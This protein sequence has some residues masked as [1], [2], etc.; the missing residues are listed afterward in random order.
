M[1]YKI[2]KIQINMRS[3]A[4]ILHLMCKDNIFAKCRKVTLFNDALFQILL[5]IYLQTNGVENDGGTVYEIPFNLIPDSIKNQEVEGMEVTMPL[6]GQ[7]V[8]TYTHDVRDENNC[9]IYGKRKGDAV[10]DEDNKLKSFDTMEVFTLVHTDK[11]TGNRF[12]I[13]D[14]QNVVDHAK[15]TYLRKVLTNQVSCT[16]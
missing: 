15:R 12:F 3:K 2:Y 1:K 14:P 11:E 8:K 5:K 16:V 10:C 13:T 9:V 6:G 7:Y 4:V